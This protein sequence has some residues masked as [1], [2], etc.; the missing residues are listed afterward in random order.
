MTR[1][2]TVLGA[3][4]VI[5][6]L[7]LEIIRKYPD[8]FSV[9]AF[10][11]RRGS[12]ELAAI[13]EEFTPRHVV[14]QNKEDSDSL[15][16][17][18]CEKVSVS[19]GT[20]S[21]VDVCSST[22]TDMVIAG[23]VGSAGL[24]PLLAAVRTG[25]VVLIAN[26]EPVV[27]L[28][29][30]LRE[31]LTKYGATILPIDSEHNAIFQ[32]SASSAQGKYQCF[33]PI[34]GLRRILLTGTGGPFLK[35]PIESLEQ[36]TPEQAVA[37]PVWNM[38]K[39]VSVDSATMMNKGLEIFEARWLFDTPSDKIDVVVHPQ[40]FVHSM[41]E[42]QDGSVIAQMALPDMRVA[43]ANALF[44]PERKNGGAGYM[45]FTELPKLEFLP[46][47]M[48]RFPC[49]K[50]ARDL[51]DSDGTA[52]VVMNGAN[53]IAVDAFLSSSVNYLEIPRI[54]RQCVEKIGN[55]RIESVEQ[56]LELDK[57]AKQT[58]HSLIKSYG[59]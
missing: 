33:T 7:T 46:P 39:K 35:M 31:E 47:D 3:T 43:I 14:V 18:V 54:V 28:G 36:V 48:D 17:I 27:M 9:F 38:G 22:D 40:G 44:W 6:Q 24:E 21:L 23:I 50:L 5:G 41:V 26:K 53:E 55:N 13:C 2:V 16:Q 4:G 15:K 25:A 8:E 58:A 37:H 34:Q 51:A 49:L 57:I 12:R 11:A 56:I 59:K 32:C 29:P 52:A 45:D 42:Y 30:I 19:Y 20:D 10:A 1:S